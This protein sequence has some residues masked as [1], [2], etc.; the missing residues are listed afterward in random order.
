MLA[1]NGANL[2]PKRRRPNRSPGVWP[3]LLAPAGSEM[4]PGRRYHRFA[5]RRFTDTISRPSVR[6]APDNQGG[7]TGFG[8]CPEVIR[9]PAYREASGA[10]AHLR[11]RWSGGAV[12]RSRGSRAR[13]A[14][15]L[16]TGFLR[17]AG[18]SPNCQPDIGGRDW[19]RTSDMPLAGRLLSQ[20]SYTPIIKRSNQPPQAACYSLCQ[21]AS[22]ASSS[23]RPGRQRPRGHSVHRSCTCRRRSRDCCRPRGKAS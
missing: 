11:R 17:T 8:H 12:L 15:S 18:A 5:A 16:C 2:Y 20:L 21:S 13:S 19:P 1:E 14:P 10:A 22:K 9:R 23:P 3:G 4:A 6:S 7:L